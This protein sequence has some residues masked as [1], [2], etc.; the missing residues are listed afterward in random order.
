MR[1]LIYRYR[2]ADKNPLS[3]GD[4]RGEDLRWFESSM[5][6]VADAGLW[7]RLLGTAGLLRVTA[8]MNYGRRF[9]LMLLADRRPA[10]YVC[11]KYGFC[12]YYPVGK[13]DAVIGP[14]YVHP[15]FRRRGFAVRMINA[16]MARLA[17]ENV[18]TVWVD[19][20]ATNMAMQNVIRRCGFNETEQQIED[21]IKI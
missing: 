10:G 3:L 15:E 9:M 13:R 21:G 14:V 16:A 4:D 18:D 11:V 8:L 12:R 6:I 1:K 2:F 7:Y 19:T 20:S 5:R 17:G